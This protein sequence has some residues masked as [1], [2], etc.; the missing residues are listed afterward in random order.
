MVLFGIWEAL[1][2]RGEVTHRRDRETRQGSIKIM[3]GESGLQPCLGTSGRGMNNYP[4]QK[5]E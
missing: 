5:I 1:V 2:G 4:T 3:V